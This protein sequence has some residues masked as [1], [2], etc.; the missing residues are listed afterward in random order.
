MSNHFIYQKDPFNST[1][2]SLILGNQSFDAR[3]GLHPFSDMKYGSIPNGSYNVGKSSNTGGI[4][5]FYLNPNQDIGNRSNLQI[6]P[7]STNPI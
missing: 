2:G 4:D 1:K 3:S 5:R 6:H 7:K